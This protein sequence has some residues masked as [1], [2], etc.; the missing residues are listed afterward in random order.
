MTLQLMLTQKNPT[1]SVTDGPIQAFPNT[2]R[3][4]QFF[5]S[6]RQL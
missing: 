5:W 2:H 1:F 4:S 6:S 3:H